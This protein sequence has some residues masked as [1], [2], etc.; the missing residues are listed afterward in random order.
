MRSSVLYETV[1]MTKIQQ[2]LFAEPHLHVSKAKLVIPVYSSLLYDYCRRV[3]CS[4]LDI[5]ILEQKSM[6]CRQFSQILY[7]MGSRLHM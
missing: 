4:S 5:E 2:K 3:C 7:S 6:I 1:T